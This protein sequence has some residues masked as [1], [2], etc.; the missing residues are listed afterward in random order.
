MPTN[1]ERRDANR[2]LRGLENGGLSPADAVILAE[3]LDPVLIYVIVSFLRAVHPASDP[4]ANPILQRV[5]ALSS[6]SAALV[7][8]HKEGASDPIS[9]WF[10]NEHSY[11]SFRG[12]GSQMIDRIVDK[13]ES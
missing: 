12:R 1:D 3:G 8:K 13:L 9:R 6:G 10:E 4:A 11:G 7:R 5:V 2:L